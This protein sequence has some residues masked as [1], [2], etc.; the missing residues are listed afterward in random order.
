MSCDSSKATLTADWLTLVTRPEPRLS[1][2]LNPCEVFKPT[3]SP[4]S[5]INLASHKYV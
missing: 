4:K 2:W 5:K 1:D 3:M